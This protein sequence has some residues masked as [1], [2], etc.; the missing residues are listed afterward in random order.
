MLSLIV[1]CSKDTDTTDHEA[2][3]IVDEIVSSDVSL[4]RTNLKESIYE[5]K[6]TANY[7]LHV[8]LKDPANNGAIIDQPFSINFNNQTFKKSTD[9]KGCFNIQASMNIDMLKCEGLSEKVI[10]IKAI[11]Q[12]RG[13][14]H[15]IVKVNPAGIS[16]KTFYDTRYN[17]VNY[18]KIN[19]E[20]CEGTEFVLNNYL[21]SRVEKS[22]NDLKLH[23]NFTPALKLNTLDGQRK[24]IPITQSKDINIETTLYVEANGSYSI[25]DINSL[26]TSV[27]E[28][29]IK[30][31]QVFKVNMNKLKEY[32]NKSF[33][34]KVVVSPIDSK[35]SS[36]TGNY[37]TEALS[38]TNVTED[39]NN[40]DI[41]FDNTILA[42]EDQ[43]SEESGDNIELSSIEHIESDFYDNEQ[44]AIKTRLSKVRAC[45]Y[46]NLSEYGNSIKQR[47]V[48]ITISSNEVKNKIIMHNEED[49]S[50][51]QINGCVFFTIKTDYSIF[52]NR[53]WT[54]QN[55]SY[56]FNNQTINCEIGLN[57]TN[58]RTSPIRDLCKY[59]L[60]KEDL[61][62]KEV[63]LNIRDLKYGQLTRDKD[64]YYVSKLTELFL[65]KRYYLDLSPRV[66]IENS[67]TDIK[68]SK[69]LN[70]GEMNMKFYIFSIPKNEFNKHVEEID[71][72]QLSLISATSK[73]ISV[74]SN[75]RAYIEIDLPFM[76]KNLPSLHIGT[77][78]VIELEPKKSLEGIKKTSYAMKFKG[79]K[80]SA[81]ANLF[82]IDFNL[83]EEQKAIANNMIEDGHAFT[84]SGINLTD[85][86]SLEL[87]RDYLKNQFG[88]DFKSFDHSEF[89]S[90]EKAKEHGVDARDLRR[91][92]KLKL[93]LPKEWKMNKKICDLF[94]YKEQSYAKYIGTNRCYDD[95]NRFIKFNSAK[96]IT[97][98]ATHNS[99]KSGFAKATFIESQKT[100]GAEISRGAA[101]MAAHG[102]RAALMWGER[103]SFATS[104]SGSLYYDGP[105]S[106]FFLNWGFSKTNESY[107]TSVNTL[108]QMK[109]KR[110]FTNDTKVRLTY[111]TI[112]LEYSAYY[113]SCTLISAY[114]KDETKHLHICDDNEKASKKINE[115]WYF[116]GE[117]GMDQST[118]LNQGLQPGEKSYQRI[119]R[120]EKNFIQML[121]N[122]NREDIITIVGEMKDQELGEA[123]TNTVEEYKFNL[124]HKLME[125]NNF[126]G[127]V[128]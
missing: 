51:T 54:K 58:E 56:N 103:E 26:K 46:D 66:L 14:E 53:S 16:T 106:V 128:R 10:S 126:P 37:K 57:P 27:N 28:G 6:D 41:V 20:N 112:G 7:D 24:L 17:S 25:I 48:N 90:S 42:K 114:F 125:D 55:I 105:P 2:T 81:N 22:N 21:I 69:V 11:G 5:F 100:K 117:V 31:D 101:T 118:I 49:L 116:I 104:V 124:K 75:G 45:F 127:M 89:L 120:G 68:Q 123:F 91:I 113:K 29:H 73:E 97:R 40:T 121:E 15:I 3:F 38:F 107:E 95:P 9:F 98:V 80:D 35:L 50:Q 47:D 94:G 34:V 13:T 72:D 111:D 88:A 96:H 61:S 77:Y 92:R 18:E 86:N 63:Q 84:K 60:N 44:S 82:K 71:I 108:M 19:S 99:Q 59:N 74:D 12:Y 93:K 32:E 87:F 1:S 109:F 65:K 102:A 70:F 76:A 79:T 62:E 4:T 78:A 30:F 36:Y 43:N 110:T 52:K 33:G 23:F 8:C 83:N 119:I 67:E 122:F 39:L 85:K 115:K 64:G